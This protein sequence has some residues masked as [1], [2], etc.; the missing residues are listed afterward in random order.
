MTSS[1]STRGTRRGE[2]NY[3]QSPS[4][5]EVLVSHWPKQAKKEVVRM[6][7]GRRFVV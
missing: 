1:E 3:Y 7:G 6:S 2:E 4:F 5:N